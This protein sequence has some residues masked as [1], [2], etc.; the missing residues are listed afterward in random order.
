M[1]S[2][3]PD[4]RSGCRATHWSTTVRRGGKECRSSFSFCSARSTPQQPVAISEQ[5]LNASLHFRKSCR[6]I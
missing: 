4:P 6:L 1:V 2:V 3:Q 5:Q